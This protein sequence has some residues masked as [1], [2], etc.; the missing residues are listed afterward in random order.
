MTSTVAQSGT[1]AVPVTR[2][3]DSGG[4]VAVTDVMVTFAG[5]LGRA[6]F[7]KKSRQLV[8]TKAATANR[9]FKFHK[10]GQ[11]FIRTHNV[12]LTVVTMRVE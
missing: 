6:P 11:L 9:R 5:H 3:A 10:S 8:K 12:A 7:C 2:T 4:P 1:V